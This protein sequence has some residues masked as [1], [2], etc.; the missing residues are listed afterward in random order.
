M[1]RCYRLVGKAKLVEQFKLDAQVKSKPS[2]T[3]I[4][5][6]CKIE[7]LN[8]AE[9]CVLLCCFFTY[10]EIDGNLSVMI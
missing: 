7:F 2:E 4:S 5:D 3:H 6:G 9:T 1:R 10:L 8:R